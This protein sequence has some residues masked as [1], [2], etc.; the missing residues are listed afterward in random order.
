MEKKKGFSL[1]KALIV[2][3][4]I[5][6]ILVAVAAN[7]FFA[8]N[9]VP[10]FGDNYIFIVH[11]PNPMPDYVDTG[12]A[13]MAKS[14]DN[15]SITTGDIVLCYPAD[16][17]D[18][19]S[20]RSINAIVNA[21]DGSEMY[22]TRDSLHEDNSES[23]AKDKIAAVCTG[24][25]ES[26]ELGALVTFAM[27]MK[28]IIAMLLV[29]CVLLVIMLIVKFAA[30]KDI[31]ESEF[32]F[33]E[34]DEDP[35]AEKK[36]ATGPLFDPN[37]DTHFSDDLERKKQS[38]ADNFSQK[39]VNPESPYQKEKE[40]TMQFKAQQ[41]DPNNTGTIG[42]Y[43]PPVQTNSAEADFAAR[44][45]A[46]QSSTAPTADA[47]REE[48]LRKT[49]EA[50]RTGTFT[51]KTTNA[52]APQSTGEYASDITGVISKAQV[53]QMSREEAPARAAAPQPA[54]PAPAPAPKKSSTPD[55]SDILKKTDTEKKRSAS[56]A[57][58]VDDLIAMIEN[59]KNKL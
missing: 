1:F 41:L 19:L 51:I 4:C 44:N 15:I 40:R 27:S 12:S 53:E 9:K 43:A 58:S 23:I 24:Y 16:A 47:L 20:L 26:P 46:S 45:M 17:P 31:D 13:L 28:G 3:I 21:E 32:D 35:S 30:G 42:Q 29:P 22:F 5:V 6:A 38:I 39:K 56:S 18:T 37:A 14:A 10:K 25:P 33:Y 49:S 57:M 54:K 50:E 7:V 36:T 52:I 11:E 8:K 59:E 2:I 34:Y 55:I 48:M